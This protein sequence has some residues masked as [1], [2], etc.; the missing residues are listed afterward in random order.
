MI[1]VMAGINRIDIFDPSA[2]QERG[3]KRVEATMAG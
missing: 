1:G 2:L 3:E